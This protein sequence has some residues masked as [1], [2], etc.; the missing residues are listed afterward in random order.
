MGQVLA[1]H[2]P[3][4][5]VASGQACFLAMMASC[6]AIEPS[7]VALKRG[8]SFYGTHL[9]TVVPYSLGFA[10]CVGLTAVGLTRLSP[11]D[12]SATRL[13][14][15]LAALIGL[16][17]LIPLTPYSVDLVFDYLHIGITATVFT[18]GLALGTW[19]ALRVLR[20]GL[21]LSALA[22]QLGAGLLAL[23]AQLGWHD[24][25]I[26]SQLGFQLSFAVLVVLGILRGARRPAPVATA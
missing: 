20:T 26:P 22:A 5:F 19:L 18:A 4:A 6:L 11:I 21:A 13:R 24:Y 2:D 9:Q 25:M 12:I 17:A 16:M 14:L 10:L 1:R 3:A 8:L 7:Q 23:T 15:G